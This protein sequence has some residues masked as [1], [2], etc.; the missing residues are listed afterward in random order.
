LTAA[1]G[2][3]GSS[4]LDTAGELVST[5]RLTILEHL[6]VPYRVP[7]EHEARPRPLHHIA[8]AGGS[9]LLWPGPS[10]LPERAAIA[11]LGRPDGTQITLCARL[12][13]ERAVR[14]LL[15]GDGR[16][17]SAVATI[18]AAGQPVAKV[19]ADA[20]GNVLLPFDPDEAIDN[21]LSERYV[22]LLARSGRGP[23]RRGML[24]AYYRVRGLLPRA[25]QI[26]MRRRYARVQERTPFPRWPVET[27]L[28]DFLDL[29]L[30]ILGD[31]A[32][33]P[34]PY[35]A[36]W[37]DGHEWALV[38][39][40][41]VETGSGVRALEPVLALERGLGLRSSWYF[42][43]RRYAVDDE[44]VAE[45]RADGFEVGVHGLRH[46]G[47]DMSSLARL[48]QR[49]P[50]MHEAARRWQAVG[51]R[52]PATHR[53]WPWM[54]L[55]GFDYDSSYPDTDPFEPQPG[56][57]CSWWPFF[58]RD[59]VELPLTMPHD[60]TLF[61]ILGRHDAST[62]LAKA[63]LL[64]RRGG[65]A[66]LVTHPDYLTDARALRAYQSLLERYV[67]DGSAWHAVPAQ[68]SSWW[69]QRSVLEIVRSGSGWSVSGEGAAR[70]RI[71]LGARGAWQ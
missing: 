12:L 38:L 18:R 50:A 16:S 47:R 29:L 36:P 1:R 9:R 15:P 17:W 43:P 11:T 54:P 21:L 48:R 35:L 5:R 3:E 68:V 65:M 4:K 66:L 57:C 33:A 59:L 71:K 41:D 32:G 45:L 8:A 44:L 19:F 34:V 31:I 25:T 46:D 24:Y 70:A 69:R 53:C 26:W 28:H 20:D 27:A 2:A 30:A 10:Q 42:V 37:P 49:L 61:V 7:A 62:W 13:G 60:H 40:H 67:G 39:T 6:R 51:F 58:N 55:L 63:E 64:R 52:S 23:G 56:G 22:H 14:A